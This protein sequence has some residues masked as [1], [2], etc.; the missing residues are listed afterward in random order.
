MN[1]QGDIPGVLTH[2]RS[3]VQPHAWAFPHSARVR[4][5]SLHMFKAMFKELLKFMCTYWELCTASWL[6]P[7]GQ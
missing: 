7:Y 1:F 6:S 4:T 2:T 5:H 3:N